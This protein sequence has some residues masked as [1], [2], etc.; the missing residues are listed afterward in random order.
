M[1]SERLSKMRMR[2]FRILKHRELGPL[3]TLFRRTLCGSRQQRFRSSP[4]LHTTLLSFSHLLINI[5]QRKTQCDNPLLWLELF[6]SR[7]K[8]H[9]AT[10]TH[11]YCNNQ[12][13]TTL[14]H[15]PAQ[16]A[17]LTIAPLNLTDVASNDTYCDMPGKG[18]GKE[19]LGR[20]TLGLGLGGLG[21]SS[22]G[23]GGPKRHQ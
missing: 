14:L 13:Q 3:I 8:P 1:E 6:T 18:K 17:H 9:S 12:G 16:L 20:G 2:I 23:R 22:T 5:V 11:C 10:A 4:R 19:V 7:D 21:P 15:G